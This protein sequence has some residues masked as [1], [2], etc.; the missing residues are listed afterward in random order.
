MDTRTKPLLP[1]VLAATLSWTNSAAA[2]EATV[3]RFDDRMTGDWGGARTQLSQRGLDMSLAYINEWL[4]NTSGGARDA[5]AYADQFA[6]AISA[7]LD[8]ILDWWRSDVICRG[9]WDRAW[10]IES[11]RRK[12][13][14][15]H[16]TVGNH[17]SGRVLRARS[18]RQHC[19]HGSCLERGRADGRR[20]RA[21]VAAHR[22]DVHGVGQPRNYFVERFRRRVRI[23][24]TGRHCTGPEQSVQRHR[25]QRDGHLG[26]G[27]CGDVLHSID[28]REL[29]R[30]ECPLVG[31]R[32]HC[33]V[34][35]HG[36]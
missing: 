8:T 14:R 32:T 21:A 4:H 11:L 23:L 17:R 12:R 27:R 3:V 28:G 20:L 7:D 2:K 33:A 34:I 22:I 36:P 10:R 25:G 29:L 19:G 35:V 5:T 26:N 16:A 15:R 6:L 13:G 30:H 18:W 31:T 9:G 24:L 1:M